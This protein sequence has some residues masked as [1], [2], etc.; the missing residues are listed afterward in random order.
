MMYSLQG[1][2]G[3]LYNEEAPGKAIRRDGGCPEERSAL[4]PP[5]DMRRRRYCG[6]MR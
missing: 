3:I 2:R 5:P 6:S 1:R 4:S